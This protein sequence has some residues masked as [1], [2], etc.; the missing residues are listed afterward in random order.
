[1]MCLSNFWS[2][3][4]HCILLLS[5]KM[6]HSLSLSLLSVRCSIFSTPSLFNTVSIFDY[7]LHFTKQGDGSTSVPRCPR[8]QF[9]LLLLLNVQRCPSPTKA[10]VLGAWGVFL[11]F[12]NSDYVSHFHSILDSAGLHLRLYR[13]SC[14]FSKSCLR[15]FAPSLW[16]GRGSVT[17][18]VVMRMRLYRV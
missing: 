6:S 11:S 5:A 8:L 14:P 16:R 2:G 13:F 9:W 17:L 10:I 4:V 7:L 3:L 1:M 18:P 12:E 15:K